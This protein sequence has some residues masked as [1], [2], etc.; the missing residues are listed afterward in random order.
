SE[1]CLQVNVFAP[2][3]GRCPAAGCPVMVWIHGGSLVSGSAMESAYN[4]AQLAN[5]QN[6]TVAAINYRLGPY[7]FPPGSAFLAASNGSG[8][9]YGFQDARA[10]LTWVK[11]N[12][13]AFGGDPSKIT[14]FGESAGSITIGYLILNW[15]TPAFNRAIMESGTAETLAAIN[16]V[17]ANSYYGQM[18]RFLNLT[19]LSA[20]Q[21]V[22]TMKALPTIAIDGAFF[23]GTNMTKDFG[24][25]LPM[26][27]GIVVKDYPRVQTQAKP[28]PP[29][30]AVMIGTNQD[31]G[32]IFVG[33]GLGKITTNE[34]LQEFWAANFGPLYPQ[35]VTAVYSNISGPF[36][37]AAASVTD[38][39]FEAPTQTFTS[40]VGAPIYLYRFNSYVGIVERGI[41]AALG[42]GNLSLGAYH[43]AE[44]PFVFDG[45]A[46]VRTAEE[47]ATQKLVQ[48]A[49]GVFARGGEPWPRFVPANITKRQAGVGGQ[50]QY[51]ARNG[52]GSVLPQSQL[53]GRSHGGRIRLRC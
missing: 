33:G 50:V 23:V 45:Y 12:I 28:R 11:N 43:S 17:I 51:F 24:G 30:E 21:Q 36:Y 1:Q 29:L 32:T 2:P 46:A 26:I 13:A 39:V 37:K 31:E 22:A 40:D 18:T 44:I 15:P 47:N 41:Q 52:T 19:G 27:D 35:P 14:V 4:G 5:A 53:P 25:A 9:N 42:L 16:S 20:A 8:T 49:W 7:G 3:Q 38:G 10:G 48:D 34:S 6:V